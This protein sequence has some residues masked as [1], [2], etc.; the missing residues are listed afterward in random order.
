MEKIRQI[1]T[2]PRK[3]QNSVWIDVIAKDLKAIDQNVTYGFTYNRE[4]ER[5]AAKNPN[6][7]R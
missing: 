3:T 4:R 7:N 1:K 5:E 6:E 2:R